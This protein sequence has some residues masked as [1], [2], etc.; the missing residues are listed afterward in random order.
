MELVH[1]HQEQTQLHQMLEHAPCSHNAQMQIQIKQH[2]I[3][4]PML[5]TSTQQPQM[6]Q[7]L[8]HA[9]H[10][11]VQPERWDHHANQFH[12]GIYLHIKFASLLEPHVLQETQHH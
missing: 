11:L 8:H 4:E 3:P 10:T 5:A 7:Q 2:V 6:E 12:H 9:H 1:S